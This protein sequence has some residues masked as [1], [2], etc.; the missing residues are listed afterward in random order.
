MSRMYFREYL[1]DGLYVEFDGYQT[2][3]SADRDG[4]THE[5][6]LEPEV[7]TNFLTWV[8]KLNA[9]IESVR[10]RGLIP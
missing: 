5:V 7:L 9:R 4:T 10:Q 8:E 3:L 1:G 6:F 2:R